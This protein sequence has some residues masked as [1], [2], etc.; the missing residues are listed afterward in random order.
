MRWRQTAVW[1]ME[2]LCAHS[3]CIDLDPQPR[4]R[5][6]VPDNSPIRHI[7]VTATQRVAACSLVCH[8]CD[9]SGTALRECGRK[10]HNMR[11]NGTKYRPLLAAKLVVEMMKR[12]RQR[13]SCRVTDHNR[14]PPQQRF[15]INDVHRHSRPRRNNDDDHDDSSNNDD[16]DKQENKDNVDDYDDE[17]G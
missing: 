17:E 15:S 4:Q 16:E 6:G 3:L 8:F 10:V 13:R 7:L 2:A 11:T 5:N 1:Q 12:A 9:N 14:Q